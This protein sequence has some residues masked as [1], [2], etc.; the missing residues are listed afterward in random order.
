MPRVV[1]FD[2]YGSPDVLR[3]AEEPERKPA[4][5]EVRIRA[6]ALGF[7]V[8]DQ[9][10]R[11]GTY[12][13][14]AK[15]PGAGLGYEVCGVVDVVGDHVRTVKPGDVVSSFTN[16]S[17]NDYSAHAESVLLP[18]RCVTKTPA[19][20]TPEQGAT[21]WNPFLTA[22]CGI[23]ELGRLEPDSVV[24]VTAGTSSVGTAAIQVGKALGATVVTTTRSRGHRERLERL[25]ADHVVVSGDDDLDRLVAEM[26]DDRGV[27]VVF[28]A[29]GGAPFQDFG[30]IA[31]VRGRLISYGVLS[32]EMPVV[33]LAEIMAKDL[34]IEV[35]TLFKHTG[36]RHFNAVGQPE[37]VGRASRFILDGIALGYLRP[38]VT[39]VFDGLDR[40][41]EATSFIAEGQSAGKVALRL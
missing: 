17:L 15:L 2:E 7:M 5:D 41:V 21:F 36:N 24:L 4:P 32:G 18:E 38:V 40:Y 33:P 28:D 19:V 22:Y 3:I 6:Q 14:P 12:P 31:A 10:Y 13:E 16:F 8:A 27:D 29:I 35:Y 1:R 37:V 34:S 20:L 9:M 25:G 39:E 11:A 23:V 30:A 26:T